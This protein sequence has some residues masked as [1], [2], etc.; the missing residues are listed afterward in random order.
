M[1]EY[2][3]FINGEF[4]ESTK[5][6]EIISPV[7]EEVLAKISSASVDD[8]DYA[9]LSAR[10]ALKQWRKKSFK[11]RAIVLREI[12]KIILD[13]LSELAEIESKEIGKPLK[14]SL[15]VDIPLA[16]DV[17]DYYANFLEGL[18]GRSFFTENSEDKISYLPYGVCGIYLP[19]NVPLMIFGFTAAG[20]LAGGNTLIIKPSEF[21]S[22]SILKLAEYVAKSGILKGLINV[23]TGPGEMI[24]KSLARSDIDLISFTGSRETLKHIVKESSVE[25]KKIICELG[26]CNQAVI[27]KDADLKQAQE[28]ILASSFMKQG[29]ICIGTSLVLIEDSVYPE[30]IS[31]LVEKTEKITVGDPFDPLTGCGAVISKR[32]LEELDKKV[33]DILK[34]GGRIL[35]GGERLKKKG[36]FYKPTIIE[37]NKVVYEEF[38]GPVIMVMPFRNEKQVEEIMEDNPTGLITQIWTSDL[39]KARKLANDCSAGTVWINTFAQMSSQTPFGGVKKSG[40]GRNLGVEGFFEYVQAKHVGIGFDSS[41]VIGWFGE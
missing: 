17:F 2:G 23:L 12:K 10:T 41:P 35:C 6:I 33:K 34:T 37:I 16:A 31:S 24:G 27:F 5:K 28:N 20:A 25:P 32:H 18:E 29:Q 19:Y 4:K 39:K 38:F 21:A 15:F 7:T 26:G 8:L 9:L 30:V 1:Q 13:N 40:F 36:F 3:C 11:E 14:E 22:L